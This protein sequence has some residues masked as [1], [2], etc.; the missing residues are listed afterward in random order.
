M[1]TT[2]YWMS[3]V[4][5]RVGEKF[6]RLEVSALCRVLEH[7][8][9]VLK[10]LWGA[11][12]WLSDRGP[13]QEAAKEQRCLDEVG[14]HLLYYIILYYT[15]LYCILYSI[16]LFISAKLELSPGGA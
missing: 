16:I 5:H 8:T 12:K 10:K 6:P 14:E 4:S 13:P 7:G 11:R 15:I 1:V 3:M 9:C 2:S